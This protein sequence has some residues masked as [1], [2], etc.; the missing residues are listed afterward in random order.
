MRL[1]DRM[2][3]NQ[4]DVQHSFDSNDTE[5]QI[6][7]TSSAKRPS[8]Q[9]SL[10]SFEERANPSSYVDGNGWLRIVGSEYSDQ[11]TVHYQAGGSYGSYYYSPPRVTVYENGAA[12]TFNATWMTGRIVFEG[13]GGHDYFNSY[14]ESW[15]VA[16][17][18]GSGNDTLI[19]YNGRDYLVGGEDD[20][21]LWGWGGD[22]S[23]DGGAGQD[24]LYGMAGSDTLDGGT[25][26]DRLNGGS[27][28]DYFWLPYSESD[29]IE[30]WVHNFDGIF[31]RP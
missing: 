29:Q 5:E 7:S 31:R 16:A 30:D 9:L 13:K 3:M 26:W 20:D 24:R 27:E 22:D 28:R 17:W 23:M 21:E 11:L 6:M 4:A 25:G 10:M 14:I 12:S 15:D 8:A 2:A 1:V 18:G 19:G